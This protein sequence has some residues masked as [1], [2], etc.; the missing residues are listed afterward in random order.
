MATIRKASKHRGYCILYPWYQ[1]QSKPILMTTPL[2]KTPLMGHTL[3]DPS[4][5]GT[6]PPTQSQE[7]TS[8]TVRSI[9]IVSRTSHPSAPAQT[10]PKISTLTPISTLTARTLINSRNHSQARPKSRPVGLSRAD[11][12]DKVRPL[13]S[14]N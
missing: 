12:P 14:D 3:S 5:R 10:K 8:N 7:V 2:G 4:S 13:V 6:E 9:Q 11:P 1:G